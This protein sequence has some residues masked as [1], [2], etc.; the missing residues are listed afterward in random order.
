MRI[1]VFGTGGAGGFF[2]AQLARAGEDV[3]FVARSEHLRAIR[4]NGLRVETRGGEIVIFFAG[5]SH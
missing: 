5:P 2:G 3:I 4:A 1:M